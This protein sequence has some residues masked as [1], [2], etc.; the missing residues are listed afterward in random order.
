MGLM[1]VRAAAKRRQ[2]ISKFRKHIPTIYAL[3]VAGNSLRETC[4][5]LRELHS[6]EGSA[7][8]LSR[9]IQSYPL[10]QPKSRQRSFRGSD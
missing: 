4:D 10:L 5:L 7:S 6:F 3:Q 1:K 8:G 9:F 2:R